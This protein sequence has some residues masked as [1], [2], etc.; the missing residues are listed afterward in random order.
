MQGWQNPMDEG[1]CTRVHRVV[2][3]IFVGTEHTSSVLC[4]CAVIRQR[5]RLGL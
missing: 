4:Q 1:L 3:L 5:D 2:K